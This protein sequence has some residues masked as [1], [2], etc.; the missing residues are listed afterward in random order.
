MKIQCSPS[1]R[2]FGRCAEWAFGPHLICDEPISQHLRE[3]HFGLQNNK[4]IIANA[5]HSVVT[6]HDIL[7]PGR[8]CLQHQVTDGLTKFF[9]QLAKTV[10]VETVDGRNLVGLTV[11][12][13]L[14]HANAKKNAL[15]KAR[16]E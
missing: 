9:V 15:W 8:C 5:S 14:A 6:P 16:K 4:A 13:H 10:K 7:K 2:W 12:Y 3:F 11:G 1:K